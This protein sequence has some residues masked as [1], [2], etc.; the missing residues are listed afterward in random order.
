MTLLL[1]QL[2]SELQKLFGKKRTYIGFLMFPL[3]QALILLLF[4]FAAGPRRQMARLLEANGY[5]AADYVSG[6]TVATLMLF[7][8]AYL[9][10]PLYVSLMGGDLVAKEVEDGT[11]RMILCRPISRLRLLFLKWVAGAIFSIGLV[12]TLGLFGLAVSWFCFGGGGLFVF[13]PGEAFNVFPASEG[14]RRYV[15]AHLGLSVKAVT[16]MGLAFLFSCAP[17]KPATA[18]ILALSCV[19]VSSILQNIPYF[20][21]FEPWFLTHYLDCWRLTF[22]Q[23][24]P[25]W[26]AAQALSLLAGFNLS[27][28]AIGAAVFYVRDIK[29]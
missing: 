10:L 18:T 11:L 27:F 13:V 9:L 12:L 26:K 16:I 24:V 28:F 19:F 22:G 1:R 21:D 2:Q 5:A 3:G 8:I 4:R 6:L 15:A 20:R 23:P 25:V 29:T 14:W 7:P 17:V